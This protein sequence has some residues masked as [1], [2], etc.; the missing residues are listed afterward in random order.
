MGVEYTAPLCHCLAT[1]LVHACFCISTALHVLFAYIPL[2]LTVSHSLM[3]AC[4]FLCGS[5][6]CVVLGELRRRVQEECLAWR[7]GRGGGGGGGGGGPI[8]ILHYFLPG[9]LIT[10]KRRTGEVSLSEC[11]LLFSL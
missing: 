3:K 4:A 8:F 7:C 6:D 2:P 5:V 1:V 9:A 10:L 11:V